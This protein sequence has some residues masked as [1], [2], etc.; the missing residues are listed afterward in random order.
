MSV[1]V[2]VSVPSNASE[3]GWEIGRPRLVGRRQARWTPSSGTSRRAGAWEPACFCINSQHNTTH[4][5]TRK[6]F[7]VRAGRW[8]EGLG[9]KMKYRTRCP[10]LSGCCLP[11][12]KTFLRPSRPEWRSKVQHVL[13]DVRK[14]LLLLPFSPRPGWI[15]REHSRKR[16]TFWFL[17]THV[18]R[19]AVPWICVRGRCV[20]H[21][22]LRTNHR[23]ARH[24]HMAINDRNQPSEKKQEN[25]LLTK[26]ECKFP[27]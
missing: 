5:K 23:H 24:L 6:K 11:R 25:L 10:R 26:R 15:S 16:F 22:S 1:S 27:M 17:S 13:Y 2:S 8:V 14:L 21:G 7:S 3:C 18:E 9:Q 12:P 20:R 4:T 19:R